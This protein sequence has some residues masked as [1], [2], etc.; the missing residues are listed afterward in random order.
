MD[1]LAY[2]KFTGRYCNTHPDKVTAAAIE[3]ALKQAHVA[4]G[5]GRLINPSEAMAIALGH[6]KGK[7]TLFSIART[8]AWDTGGDQDDILSYLGERYP[9]FA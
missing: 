6:G 7:E 9:N 2:R 4:L 5:Q 1:D 8:V 3:L